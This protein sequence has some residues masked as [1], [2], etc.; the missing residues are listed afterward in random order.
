VKILPVPVE[1][2]TSNQTIVCIV[3]YDTAF[4]DEY[5]AITAANG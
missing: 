2:T 5:D 4:V 1:F 3:S